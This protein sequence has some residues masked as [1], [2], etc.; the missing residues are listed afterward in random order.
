[1][2]QIYV[3]EPGAG[4]IPST[5]IQVDNLAN[6][7]TTYEHTIRATGG[8]ETLTITM[9]VD[10]DEATEWLANGLMRSV[11]VYSPD[12][13]LLWEGY[14][15]TVTMQ[16]GQET[17]SRSI[18][19]MSNRVVVHYTTYLGVV[20]T[21]GT[22]TD[23][24]STARYG[25]KT[26]AE[27]PST[28]TESA[29]AGSLRD[30]ILAQYKDP[31]TTPT[32]E[33]RTGEL[34]AVQLTLQFVGW[35]ETSGWLL[36]NSSSTTET[37]TTTQVG[38]LLGLLASGNAFIATST[39]NI[40]ASGI[41]DTE[42]IAT[43]TPYRA[44]IETM[45]GYGNS[46]DQRLAWGVYDDRLF[47]VTTWAGATPTVVHYTRALADAALLDPNGGDIPLWEARPDR[48]YQVVD[49][50]DVAPGATADT[51]ARYYVERIVFG[52]DAGGMSLQLEPQASNSVDAQI[53]RMSR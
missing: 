9:A 14:L 7:W 11:V 42:F 50:L 10:L 29:A 34:G 23:T 8:F 5:A 32:T 27:T 35:Y 37:S 33:V 53:A 24:A 12:A 48:M 36:G 49:L 39:A 45:L 18:R 25:I 51:V 15:E 1:M 19:E 20:L 41:D 17:R 43:D 46:A 52:M 2:F 4:G 40:A 38:T 28:P 47:H 16:A 44:K 26:R 30:R 6:R 21:V 3:F 13:V 31:I 22:A